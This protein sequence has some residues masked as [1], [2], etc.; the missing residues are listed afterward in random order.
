MGFPKLPRPRPSSCG[1]PLPSHPVSKTSTSVYWLK[2]CDRV[3]GSREALWDFG[4]DIS[5]LRYM[6]GSGRCS[7][8]NLSVALLRRNAA[9]QLV[10]AVVQELV[11]LQVTIDILGARVEGIAMDRGGRQGGRETPMLFS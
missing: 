7:P 3:Y 4:R 8:R 9:P 2:S 1:D 10:H 6:S 11:G 5:V